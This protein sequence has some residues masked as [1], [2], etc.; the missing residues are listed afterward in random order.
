MK[1]KLLATKE[2]ICLVKGTRSISSSDIFLNVLEQ[3]FLSRFQRVLKNRVI[4]HDSQSGFRSN[5]RLQFRTLMLID[6]ISLLMSTSASVTKIFVD[7]IGRCSTS[8]GGK[9]V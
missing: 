1:M 9:V 5:F 4:L 6:E 3:L 8:F 2:S 7:F